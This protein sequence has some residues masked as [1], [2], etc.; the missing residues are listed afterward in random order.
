MKH[1]SKEG[2]WNAE[3]DD[4]GIISLFGAGEGYFILI[5]III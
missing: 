4:D 3:H 1:I 2:S 5:F